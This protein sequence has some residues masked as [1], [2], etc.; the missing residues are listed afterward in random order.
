MPVESIEARLRE[1]PFVP[2]RIVTLSGQS[3][4]VFEPELEMLGIRDLIVG[5]PS[6]RN[7]KLFAAENR[8]VLSEIA[9][10]ENLHMPTA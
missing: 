5:T 10:L 4:E 2:F 3:Y 8:V 1:R 9:T 7:P 6:K